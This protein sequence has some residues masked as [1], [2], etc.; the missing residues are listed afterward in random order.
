MLWLNGCFKSQFGPVNLYNAFT[1]ESLLSIV[2]AESMAWSR[3]ITLWTL[4]ST[5]VLYSSAQHVFPKC[6][7]LC[8]MNAGFDNGCFVYALDPMY[9]ILTK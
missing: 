7:S 2:F 9:V 5:L 1:S 8:A 4:S 3:I 6:A